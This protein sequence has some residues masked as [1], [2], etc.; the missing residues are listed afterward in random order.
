VY[1]FSAVIREGFDAPVNI[2][3]LGVIDLSGFASRGWTVIIKF[4]SLLDHVG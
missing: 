1:H 3:A 2:A 4:F